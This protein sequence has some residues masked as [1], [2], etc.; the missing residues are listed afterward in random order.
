MGQIATVYCRV[1]TSDQNCERQE[2]DLIAFAAKADY[3]V[4]GVSKETASGSKMDRQQRQQVLNLAQA[5]KID[6]ILVTELT[7]WGRSTLDLF[8]TLNYLHNPGV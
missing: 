7:R 8:H 3:L 4:A 6:I 2:T 5:R 1:S